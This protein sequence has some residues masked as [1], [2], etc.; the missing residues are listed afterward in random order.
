MI[1]C[2]YVVII[3]EVVLV[4]NK[5]LIVVTN[6]IHFISQHLLAKIMSDH[7]PF[8]IQVDIIKLLPVKSLIRFRAVSKSWKSFIDSSEVL[9]HTG[10]RQTHQHRLLIRYIDVVGIDVEEYEIKYVSIVDD[11]DTFP[12]QK[13]VPTFPL[14]IDFLEDSTVAGTSH[15]LFCFYG[16]LDFGPCMAV[17]WNP[18]IRKSVDVAMPNLLDNNQSETFVR[19][20]VHPDTLDPM[21]VNLTFNH[22]WRLLDTNPW[23]VKVFTL[24]SQTWRRP[25]CSSSNVLRESI[26]FARSQVVI[27]GFIYWLAFDTSS[28]LDVPDQYGN[29]IVSFDMKTE[30]FTKVNLPECLSR[31]RRPENEFSISKLRDS[32]AIFDYDRK[33]FVVWVMKP[34]VASS[35]TRLYTST[36]PH[37]YINQILGFRKNGAP[38]IEIK[39]D[40]EISNMSVLAVS[41]PDLEHFSQIGVGGRMF[42]F[43]GH[44]YMETLLLLG[45]QCTGGSFGY[46]PWEAIFF[47]D[48]NL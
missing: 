5:K 22:H 43:T 41:D 45:H 27:G 15:G 23:Q 12:Q 34:G 16:W 25:L 29:S 28:M 20:G 21:I 7:I 37:E 8:H 10:N 3:Y 13:C 36:A 24:S 32:L 30:E 18:S 9:A 35:L 42:S 46:A 6:Q 39:D 33:S 26:Q 1:D 40:S 44:F 2:V 38:I 17:I 48:A 11:D 47:R 14:S 4:N 31:W 19:F